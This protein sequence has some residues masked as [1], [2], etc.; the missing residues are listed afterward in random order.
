M[1]SQKPTPLSVVNTLNSLTATAILQLC[2]PGRAER[3]VG[4]G[5]R[6]FLSFL[7]RWLD[8]AESHTSGVLLRLIVDFRT[9][10]L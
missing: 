1:W 5:G 6:R 8:L 2:T 4:G 9:G 3:D 7:S 10:G